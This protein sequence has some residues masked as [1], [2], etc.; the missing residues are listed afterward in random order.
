MAFQAFLDTCVLYGATLCDVML[1]VASFGA[2]E[3][4]W[5]PDVIAEL[6]RNLVEDAAVAPEAAAYRI[7]EMELAF[8]QASVT[9]Y[10]DLMTTLTCHPKDRHVLA[11][12]V[13]ARSEVLVTFNLNDFPEEALEPLGV[14]AVHP[15]DFLLDQLDLHPA[16]VGRALTSLVR[17]YTRPTVTLPSVLATQ[18]R[19]GVPV[20][21][22]EV[23]RHDF[24]AT[25]K[26]D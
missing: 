8:P 12:A 24:A 19:A 1:T 15:D 13:L 2:Y 25:T 23:R 26:D 3:P 9:G 14:R 16:L 10:S 22:Q 4:H 6:E 21:A 20:F 5:S 17:R 7:A 11:A 18:A